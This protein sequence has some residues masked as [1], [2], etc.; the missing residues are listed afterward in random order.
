VTCPKCQHTNTKKFGTYG[1][2]KIQ[3]F[4]CRDCSA[5]FSPAQPKPLGQHTTKLDDAERIIALLCEGVSIRAITRLTGVHKTT[6][7]SLLLTVGAKCATLFDER[8]QNLRPRYV[9][10]DEAWTFV[11]KKQK[12]LKADDPAERGDQYLWVAL[13]S[14]TKLVMTYHVGKRDGLNAYTFVT[15]LNRR[16]RPAHRFQITTDGLEGY[17]P[18]IEEAFGADVDFA[19]LIKNYAQASTDGPDWFRPSA[20]V[21]SITTKEI[22]GQP[23]QERISTSHMERANLTWRMTLRRFTR[24]TNA[25]SKKLIN[26]EAAV[27][28]MMAFYNFCR[29][30]QTLRV[31]PAMEAGLTNR[32]WSVRDLLT[33]TVTGERAA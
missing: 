2:A 18:A 3:R 33:A 15:D 28:I 32:V 17:V 1:A 21:V 23:K 14:E 4:R 9:Q 6:I 20:R 13:D 8:V 22:I 12:R 7:L 30:H 16:I 29:V 5:T 10:A 27:A 19:Q 26:L 24:L 11:Q 31:T 25:F